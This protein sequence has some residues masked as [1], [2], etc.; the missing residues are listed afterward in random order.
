MWAGGG[1]WVEAGVLVV[2]VDVWGWYG[3]CVSE[4]SFRGLSR[5]N[6]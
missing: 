6:F 3:V 1:S 4:G 5:L 2:H